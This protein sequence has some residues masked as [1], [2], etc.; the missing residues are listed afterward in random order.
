M[1]LLR[2]WRATQADVERYNSGLKYTLNTSQRS[3]VAFPNVTERDIRYAIGERRYRDAAFLKYVNTKA[4]DTIWHTQLRIH[5]IGPRDQLK[6]TL[7][8]KR[9]D[10]QSVE[11]KPHWSGKEWNLH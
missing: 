9:F 1:D 8:L 3:N 5:F 6:K 7:F 11:Q 4:S 10:C 2:T